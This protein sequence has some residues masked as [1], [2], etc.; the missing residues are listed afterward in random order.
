[1]T[2]RA[3]DVISLG[4]LMPFAPE[5]DAPPSWRLHAACRDVDPGIFWPE[6]SDFTEAKAVCGRC[7]VL[8]ECFLDAI[9]SGDVGK[10]VVYRAGMSGEKRRQMR[11]R[12]SVVREC[13]SC[14]AQF[15][16]P[17][18]TTICSDLCRLRA[19]RSATRRWRSA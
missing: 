14:G 6:N 7:P 1:M 17:G 12:V 9:A 18:N 3:Y 2:V 4:S 15:M 8:K 10:N 5:C 16:A 19:R 13:R 11:R